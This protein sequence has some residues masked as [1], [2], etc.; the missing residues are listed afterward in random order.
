MGDGGNS[1]MGN[2]HRSRTAG[3]PL[4]GVS[5]RKLD[6]GT[7]ME[8]NVKDNAGEKQTTNIK[9][10][11]STRLADGSICIGAHCI[12]LS[13]ASGGTEVKFD[14]TECDNDTQLA[15]RNAI[16]KGAITDFKLKANL[17]ENKS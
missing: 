2:K 16:E 5:S 8:G 7:S 10:P 17:D 14:A 3:E 6:S 4:S 12:K 11:T 13:I 1:K 9:T 15:I